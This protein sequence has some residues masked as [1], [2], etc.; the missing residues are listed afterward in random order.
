M[1]KTEKQKYSHVSNIVYSIGNIWVWRKTYV[2]AQILKVPLSILVPL[3]AIY[4]PK[5]LLD[6]LGQSASEAVLLQN[7]AAYSGVLLV[8]AVV[9]TLLNWYIE[10]YTRAFSGKYQNMR[11]EFFLT[12]DFENNENPEVHNLRNK[13]MMGGIRASW[14]LDYIAKLAT[15]L[16]G[17]FT[18]A[19]VIAMLSP[20]VLI[21]LLTSSLINF[22]VM[23]SVVRYTDK[24]KDDWNPIERR[25]D[26]LRKFTQ[27]FDF[28]KDIRLYGMSG[29]ISKLMGIAHVE[30]Y[31]WYKKVENR[32]LI[33]AFVDGALRFIRDGVAYAVLISML[34][35]GSIDLGSF[36]LYIGAVA[37]FSGWLTTIAGSFSEIL[38]H[39]LDIGYMREY[40]SY[41]SRFNRG[42]GVPL[43]KQTPFAIEFDNLTYQYPGAESATIRNVSAKIRQGEK[44]AIVGENGAGKTTLVKLLC[45]L[46]YP[47]D[48]RVIVDDK[49]MTHYNIDEYYS[50]F[51]VVFQDT[52]MIP[53]SIADYLSGMHKCDRAKVEKSLKQAGLWEA[54][55]AYP[56]GIDSMLQKSINKDS[57]ELS[58]GQKQK[59]LLARA[60]YKDAPVIVLDEPTAALDPIAESELYEKYHE[61]TQGKTSVYISHRLSSTRFCDRIFYLEKGEIVETGTHA[62]LMQLGGKYAHMFDV[63]SHYYKENVDE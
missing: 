53:V 30:R 37:G 23:R 6:L 21:M 42:K 57:I 56:Y 51:S 52:Y 59:L 34:L 10:T 7:I 9:Q 33:A 28:A 14:I 61:L 17:S 18:Y 2:I 19:A 45:G 12:T 38:S 4:F 35:S 29:W 47:T 31:V 27:S 36:V 5:L 50:L 8:A 62:E 58:G 60:L 13:A 25:I 26:Y 49:D 20:I 46:Y 55:E 44:I 24:H 3:A 40:H 48:G 43:P 63:Q 54:I 16:F 41:P 22:F 11:E 39:S 1:K 32:N 15:N